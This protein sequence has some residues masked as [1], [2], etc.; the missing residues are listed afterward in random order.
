M[1]RDE[2]PFQEWPEENLDQDNV[3][4]E[5]FKPLSDNGEVD[6]T[7]DDFKTSMGNDAQVQVVWMDTSAYL[8]NLYLV[9]TNQELRKKK[10]TNE[11]GDEIYVNEVRQIEDTEPVAT[12]QGINQLMGE[13]RTFISKDLAQGNLKQDMYNDF[14][15]DYTIYVM[16]LII[17]NRLVWEIEISDV[18]SIWRKITGSVA[19]YLTRPINNLERTRDKSKPEKNDNSKRGFFENIM[20]HNKMKQGRHN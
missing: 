18:E 8:N 13:L 5:G 14:M 12:K 7:F 6:E 9:L 4:S 1:G 17:S 11:L 15:K 16:K 20:N 3:F 19:I 2:E 10:V